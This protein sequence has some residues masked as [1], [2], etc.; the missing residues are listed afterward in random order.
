M[1]VLCPTKWL[2]NSEGCKN[3]ILISYGTRPEW[4][5]IKP[6]IKKFDGRIPFKLLFTGQH[7]HIIDETSYEVTC[8]EIKDGTNRLDSIVSSIMN[9]DK[10]FEGVSSVLVQGDTTSAFAVALA[11]FHRRIKIIHLEAGLRTYDFD[12]PY[13]EEVNRQLIARLADINLCPTQTNNDNLLSEDVAGKIY[14]VGNTVLDNLTD[15]KT[16]YGDE[17]IV[18]MHRRENHEIIPQWFTEIEKLADEHP[19]YDFIL[20]IH[21]NPNVIKHRNILSK[22]KVIDP[23]GYNDFIDRLSKSRM[24]ITDSGGIQEEASFLKKKAIVC[25]KETERIE[26]VGKF[27]FLCDEPSGLN[28]LFKDLNKNHI[29]SGECPYGD[30]HASSKILQIL[31]KEGVVKNV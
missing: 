15:V 26:V 28:S 6:L 31:L 12:N 21:P 18:T 25:R 11:A 10:V 30:G 3:M 14:I 24:I 17:I 19:E 8:L 13:P 22:V 9:N 29:P 27:S 20:P 1:C 2:E 16:E 23:L 5:K 7:K 4:I